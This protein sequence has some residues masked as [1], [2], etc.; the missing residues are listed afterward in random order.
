MGGL[1]A[2]RAPT[3]RVLPGVCLPLLTPLALRLGTRHVPSPRP[4]PRAHRGRAGGQLA[5]GG[6]PELAV[7]AVS[8]EPARSIPRPEL[9]PPPRPAF[10]RR[11]PAS[12]LPPPLG[13]LVGLCEAPDDLREPNPS[14]ELGR[15]AE[16]AF[17]GS[18]II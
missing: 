4:W 6:G 9:Q 11:P 8:P 5:G 13:G 17:F 1:G 15:N 18:L 3:P 10:C 7:G 2:R 12:L 14:G 16:A